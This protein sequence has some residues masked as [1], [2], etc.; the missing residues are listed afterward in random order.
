MRP[1]YEAIEERIPDLA[2]Y[3]RQTLFQQASA[4]EQMVNT[5]E[6]L[7]ITID[8]KRDDSIPLAM[9]GNKIRQL[10][11]YFGQA[12]SANADTV[13]ITGA[14]QSNF[15]RLCAAA[16]R[17]KKYRPI[18][19]LEDRVKKDDPLYLNSGNVLILNLLQAEIVRFPEGENEPAADANLE[20]LAEDVRRGGGRPYVI[21][22]GI[23]HPPYG[24]LGYVSAAAETYI[25]YEQLGIKPD[26]VLVPSGSGLTHSGFL[27][28]ARAIGW[29]VPVHGICV[30]RNAH[31][32]QER[33]R[34]RAAEIAAMVGV[35]SYD[36]KDVLLT[37][38]ALAPGYG[39]I[40]PAVSAAISLAATHDA[41][42]LDPVYSG[43][44]FAGLIDLVEAGTIRPG[45]R[46][47]FIHTGGTPANFA[48]ANELV[49][50]GGD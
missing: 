49:P 41:I 39:Q 18:C 36:D 20:K 25:Q 11:Y 45:E 6:E 8:I 13:L 19:Q 21:H 16:A 4:L 34:R 30:R 14:V 3:P 37:D 5:G 12:A 9:G 44:C 33:I 50:N 32:Q 48:Y 26:H 22:L 42:L 28:G 24:G 27:I 17:I 23:D 2:R 7:G 40:N 35:T 29:N 47:L 43:R 10:E 1:I 15:V 46:V 38:T 31:L